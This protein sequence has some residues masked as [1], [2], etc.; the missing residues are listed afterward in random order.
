MPALHP[1]FLIT[2]GQRVDGWDRAYPH[3]QEGSDIVSLQ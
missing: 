2:G 3:E 1:L